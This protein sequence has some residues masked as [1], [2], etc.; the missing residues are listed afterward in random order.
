MARA[1]ADEFFNVSFQAL[2]LRL[3]LGMAV[4]NCRRS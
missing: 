3:S 1:K 2:L 4:R